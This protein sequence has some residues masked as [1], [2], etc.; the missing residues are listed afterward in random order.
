MI[1][2]S[3]RIIIGIVL[4]FLFLFVIIRVIILGVNGRLSEVEITEWFSPLFTTLF[5]K[6]LGVLL[7]LI[8]AYG[9]RVLIVRHYWHTY[10]KGKAIACSI[11]VPGLLFLGIYGIIKWFTLQDQK[12]EYHYTLPKYTSGVNSSIPVS[13]SEW[14]RGANVFG[15]EALSEASIDSIRRYGIT[16]VAVLPFEYQKDI[17]KPYINHIEQLPV[18]RKKDSTVIEILK[19]CETN[20]LQVMLKPH[21]WVDSGWRT[22]FEYDKD[23]KDRWF[24]DYRKVALNYARIAQEGNASVYCFGTEFYAII[25]DHDDRWLQLIADI[26]K[27]YDGELT[28]AANWDKEYQNIPFWNTL[29]YI[30]VQ[31]YFPMKV[32][33]E[34]NI[35]T[36]QAG[37]RP[38]LDTLAHFSASNKKPVLFTE[39]G[40]RSIE[41]NTDEP[42]KW[43]QE[44]DVLTKVYSESDQ[45][46]AYRAFLKSIAGQSWCRGAYLWEYD[47][48]EDDKPDAIQ[49]LNFSPR[50][51]K[52]AQTIAE[53]YLK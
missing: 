49:W 2:K 9:V 15:W 35:E 29:D 34:K 1:R 32:K 3:L 16:H 5:W 23:Q 36:L 7:L 41:E 39:Y 22:E 14:H 19:W 30:G 40:F 44:L 20:G 18:F 52:A 37:L 47:I 53:F 6:C 27:L 46:I 33:N 50:H 25:K 26:R 43:F 17:E 21:L 51:K 4:L 45:E 28:Y 8:A 12:T 38:Y 13:K 24:Q 10:H 48:N 42:W 31:G 11:L